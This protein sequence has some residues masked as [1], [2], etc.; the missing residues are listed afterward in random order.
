MDRVDKILAG[1][2]STVKHALRPDGTNVRMY[3]GELGRHRHTQTV[4]R[5]WST[6]W[7]RRARYL[8][9]TVATFL[10][11]NHFQLLLRTQ[12]VTTKRERTQHWLLSMCGNHPLGTFDGMDCGFRKFPLGTPKKSLLCRT[13]QLPE[14]CHG[15]TSSTADVVSRTSFFF[16]DPE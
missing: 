14:T 9:E 12:T 11:Q 3:I 7:S 16:T 8:H 5:M 6:Q 2:Y 1:C 15:R 4:E 13:E 10:T